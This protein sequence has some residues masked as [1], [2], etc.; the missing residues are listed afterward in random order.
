MRAKQVQHK[1]QEAA[2]YSNLEFLGMG[3][4]TWNSVER[5]VL[6]KLTLAVGS[7]SPLHLSFSDCSAAYKAIV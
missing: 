1:L 7:N 2:E 6:G 5:Q 3:N 4:L